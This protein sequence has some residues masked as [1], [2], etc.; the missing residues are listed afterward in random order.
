MQGQGL[1][2]INKTVLPQ[3]RQHTPHPLE[4]ILFI[5]AL[6]HKGESVQPL[7]LASLQPSTLALVVYIFQNKIYI[8]SQKESQRSGARVPKLSKTHQTCS[9]YGFFEILGEVLLY[10]CVCVSFTL[11]HLFYVCTINHVC[12]CTL[13]N[14]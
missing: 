12:I 11:D 1:K 4:I 13:C 5:I 8:K 9:P 3:D 14:E 2:Y 6:K 7:T 10:R